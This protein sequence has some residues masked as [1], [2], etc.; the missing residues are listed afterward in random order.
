MISFYM[1]PNEARFYRQDG[2][3]DEICYE[4]GNPD[5]GM[6][7]SDDLRWLTLGRNLATSAKTPADASRLHALAEILK[8]PAV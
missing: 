6:P 2:K 7:A 3:L 4:A 1:L 5:P 8:N